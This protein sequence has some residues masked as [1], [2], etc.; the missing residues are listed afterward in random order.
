MVEK[1]PRGR[2]P[3]PIA[4]YT[5][6]S[7]D[8]ARR[9]SAGEWP[10]GTALPSCRVFGRQYGVGAHVINRALRAL[11]RDGRVLIQPR[12]L[13]VA[14][15]GAPLASVLQHAIAVVLRTDVFSTFS[16]TGMSDLRAGVER[17]VAQSGCSPLLYLHHASRWRS[18]FPIGLCD[19]PL[20]GVLLVG[21]FLPEMIRRYEVLKVPVVVLDQPAEKCAVHTVTAANFDAAFDATTRLIAL[22]H[23]RLAFIR[24]L[25]GS[26]KAIDPDAKER[27]EGFVAACQDAGLPEQDYKIFT[28]SY[29]RNSIAVQ[30]LVHTIPRFTAVISAND[31]HARQAASLATT[32]GLQV[33]HDLSIA[34][35]RHR[36]PKDRD[37]SGPEIDFEKIGHAAVGLLNQKHAKPQRVR[38]PCVWKTGTTVGRARR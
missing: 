8:I 9:L 20:R 13:P 26:L 23:R 14:A 6:V 12:R 37:W 25:V 21:P 10:V 30:H 35:F 2:P 11:S 3:G 19:L 36:N 16:G 34:V 24:A 29:S 22:G 1:K 15:L 38:I 33:P 5:V 7:E 27:Q 31:S 32:M 28:A 18:E 17:A 4:R